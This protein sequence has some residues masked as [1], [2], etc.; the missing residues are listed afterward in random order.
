MTRE[1]ADF[2]AS[3][4]DDQAR[5]LVAKFDRDPAVA[6]AKSDA[7]YAAFCRAWEQLNPGEYWQRADL[8]GGDQF[9]LISVD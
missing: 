8:S 1:Q 7:A 3:M 5:R 4:T 9:N 2:L 6:L